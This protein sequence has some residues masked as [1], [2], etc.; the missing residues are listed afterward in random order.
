MLLTGHKSRAS[1]SMAPDARTLCRPCPITAS[2]RARRCA[3]CNTGRATVR[4][5]GCSI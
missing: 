1:I 4:R 3:G 2:C 5:A